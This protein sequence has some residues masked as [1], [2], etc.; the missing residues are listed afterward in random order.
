M[1]E[2][3]I[4]IPEEGDWLVKYT[5]EKERD[6]RLAYLA[7]F[8]VK[9]MPAN[10][11]L[12]SRPFQVGKQQYLLVPH[13]IRDDKKA[14]RWSVFNNVTQ[15]K[16]KDKGGKVRVFKSGQK[17]QELID[18][19]N[20]QEADLIR[21]YMEAGLKRRKYRSATAHGIKLRQRKRA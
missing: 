4:Y 13:S 21:E 16:I 3:F 14:R 19:L 10:S 17:A 2:W 8:G 6:A 7:Q 1:K 9:R 11:V 12:W 15:Q 5:G 20:N 18:R